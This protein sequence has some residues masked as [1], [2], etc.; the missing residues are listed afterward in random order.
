MRISIFFSTDSNFSLLVKIFRS[1][2]RYY[3][4]LTLFMYIFFILNKMKHTI[5]YIHVYVLFFSFFVCQGQQMVDC[6]RFRESEVS[7][8]A[9]LGRP[10]HFLI[11]SLL[12][13]FLHC[14]LNCSFYLAMFIFL[15]IQSWTA[16]QRF[17]NGR[18]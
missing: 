5:K 1:S 18:R 13:S 8:W 16:F 12:I 10:T 3:I 7:L 15:N 6:T 14:V 11:D 9:I 17:F 2:L 4:L